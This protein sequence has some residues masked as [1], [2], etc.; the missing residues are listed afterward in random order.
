MD[1]FAIRKGHRYATFVM[2]LDTGDVLWVGKGMTKAAFSIF[3]HEMD[4]DYLSEVDVVAMDMNASY[5]ALV[6]EHMSWAEIAY[7]LYH[8]Q[9]QF[10][11][12]VLGAVRLDEARQHRNSVR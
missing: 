11:K 3:F 7:D 5:N 2:D 1:E 4:M 9:A 12:D 10:G 8:M 6:S